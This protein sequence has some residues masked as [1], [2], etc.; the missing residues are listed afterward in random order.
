M[1]CL[2]DGDLDPDVNA[3]S[4]SL[5]LQELS[6]NHAGEHIVLVPDRAGRHTARDLAVLR[7]I[8]LHWLPPPV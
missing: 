5:F 4:M 8:T 2:F 3:Q 6:Q 7:N 1:P